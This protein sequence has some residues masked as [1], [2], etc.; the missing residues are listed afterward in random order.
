MTAKPVAHVKS[1]VGPAETVKPWSDQTRPEPRKKAEA[2]KH[3]LPLSRRDRTR[4]GAKR[5]R[6]LF[7]ELCCLLFNYDVPKHGFPL[8]LC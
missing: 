5:K 6:K 4:L 2:V 3:V 7:R 8:L 1:C